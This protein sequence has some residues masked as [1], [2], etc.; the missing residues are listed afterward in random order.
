MNRVNVN[1]A[2]YPNCMYYAVL[3]L[4]PN[5]GNGIFLAAAPNYNA[6]VNSMPTLN[7]RITN[8]NGIDWDNPSN[9]SLN[10]PQVDWSSSGYNEHNSMYRF[11]MQIRNHST[12]N[13]GN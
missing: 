5:A 9:A 3:A 1:N 2:L 12:Q 8:C 6:P 4:P 11:F 7:W 10:K 13:N